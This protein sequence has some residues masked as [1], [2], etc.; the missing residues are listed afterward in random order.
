MYCWQRDEWISEISALPT[1]DILVYKKCIC[2]ALCTS[3]PIVT[4]DPRLT[5]HR[6]LPVAR[7]MMPCRTSVPRL[8]A[9][10]APIMFAVM[11]A[12]NVHLASVHALDPRVCILTASNYSASAYSPL[13]PFIVHDFI[14]FS[15]AV[16]DGLGVVFK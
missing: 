2:R 9:S 16:V 5:R 8:S 10:K 4:G 11:L 13:N 7:M 6:A 3:H 15:N 1:V 14:N 12:L